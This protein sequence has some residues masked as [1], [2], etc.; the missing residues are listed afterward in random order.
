V[1]AARSLYHNQQA[2]EIAEARI[3]RASDALVSYLGLSGLATA[4]FG[5]CVVTEKFW[6]LSKPLS[7]RDYIS[8]VLE[9]SKFS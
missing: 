5:V 4:R 6:S 3:E 8:P 2:R 9:N 7:D 1:R